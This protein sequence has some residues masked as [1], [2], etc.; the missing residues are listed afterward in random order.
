MPKRK[1]T[2]SKITVIPEGKTA[3]AVEVA[4]KKP[5]TALAILAAIPVIA[6]L[7][8]TFKSNF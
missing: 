4:T 7:V 3:K 1:H 5:R 6:L 2:L 8:F